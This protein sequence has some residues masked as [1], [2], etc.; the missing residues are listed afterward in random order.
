MRPRDEQLDALARLVAATASEE[1]DCEGLLA[2]IAPYVRAVSERAALSTPLQQV[3]QHLEV[4]PECKEEFV[5]LLRAE[6]LDP[7]KIL[8]P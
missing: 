5:A 8:G 4:C 3:A 7:D 2:R 6:G 1:I